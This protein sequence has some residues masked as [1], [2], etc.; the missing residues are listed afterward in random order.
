MDTVQIGGQT[1]TED[2]IEKV[3]DQVG[4]GEVK[5]SIALVRWLA[6]EVTEGNVEIVGSAIEID[7]LTLAIENVT[8]WFTGEHDDPIQY[9]L[10][11]ARAALAMEE[12]QDSL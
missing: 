6:S 10:L 4:Q 5:A 7:M 9:S 11:M 8:V 1:F 2:E 12:D 3:Y